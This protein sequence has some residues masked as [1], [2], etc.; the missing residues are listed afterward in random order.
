MALAGAALV[1]ATAAEA[2]TWKR[3]GDWDGT[4]AW[5]H[6]GTGFGFL[7]VRALNVSCRT[8]RRLVRASR[9]WEFESTGRRTGV[10]SGEGRFSE[11]TCYHRF[12]KPPQEAT[13]TRCRAPGLRRVKWVS[14]V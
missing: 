11:W 14:A 6:D 3:C 13:R 1:P 4:G 10:T 5:G 12:Y 7:D 8:A 2:A 9:N